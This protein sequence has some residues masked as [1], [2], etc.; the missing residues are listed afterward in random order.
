MAT[1]NI[2]DTIK[3]VRVDGSNISAPSYTINASGTSASG[4]GGYT[5]GS[6][7]WA[8]NTWTTSDT[9]T[10]SPNPVII[11][12]EGKISLKGKNAD[13]DIN[14]VS[15]MATLKRIEERINLLTVNTELEA[16]WDELRELGEQYRAL[17]Q[18]IKDKMETWNRLQA[19]DKDNR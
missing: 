18:R 1:N 15:L 7:T 19:Q 9:F 11:N 5:L 17:E 4:S 6:T 13:I 2:Y 12:N 3:S 10:I 14:G 16:E 8:P